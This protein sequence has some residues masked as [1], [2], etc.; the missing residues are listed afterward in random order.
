MFLNHLK[1]KAI[2]PLLFL[3]IFFLVSTGHSQEIPGSDYS[4]KE[5]DTLW[6]ISS[7]HYSDPFLWPKLWGKNLA[8]SHPDKIYPGQKIFLPSEEFLKEVEKNNQ[9]VETEKPS[10]MP[11]APKLQASIVPFPLQPEISEPE[12]EGV[13]P[14]SALTETDLFTSGFILKDSSAIGKIGE[15]IASENQH[16][17]LGEGDIVYLLPVS[18]HTFHIGERYSI[19]EV[20]RSIH[21]PQSHRLMGKLIRVKGF[22]EIIPNQMPGSRK[23]T[24]SAKI[25]KSFDLI[26]L[27]DF[28]MPYQSMDLIDLT[29]PFPKELKGTIVGT[30][31]LKEN[32]GPNDF[33]YLD[34]GSRDGVQRGHLFVVVKN[35]K[36]VPF[37]SPGG[38]ERLPQRIIAE[39]EVVS[40]QKE[41]STAIV[42]KSIE[43]VVVGDQISNPPPATP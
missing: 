34:K 22:V 33:V 29:L 35:G 16:A 10:E 32:N 40:V 13:T 36:K 5:G 23:E 14:V 1:T 37:F 15:I 25:V 27:K 12:P 4:V 11:E 21:H 30:R 42:A 28:L 2:V 26:S 19:Y 43:P 18:S 31:D 20:V 38:R 7:S 17:L 6:G 39:L 8:I 24:F 3:F 41:T 9:A